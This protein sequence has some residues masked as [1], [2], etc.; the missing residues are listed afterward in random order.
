MET[1]NKQNFCYSSLYTIY[2]IEKNSKVETKVE[3]D[4][5]FDISQQDILVI[6]FFYL[7]NNHIQIKL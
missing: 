1:G 7:N 6:L 3:I 2:G 5:W 4:E